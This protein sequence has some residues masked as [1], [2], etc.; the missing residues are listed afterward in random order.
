MLSTIL[1]GNIADTWGKI[2]H[3]PLWQRS[4]YK[5]RHVCL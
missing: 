3:T 4:F 1:T 5:H 2:Q